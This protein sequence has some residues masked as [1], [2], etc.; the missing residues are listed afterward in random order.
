MINYQK[1]ISLYT[2]ELT[3]KVM[4]FVLKVSKVIAKNFI[5]VNNR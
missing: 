5:Q 4:S 3:G 1:Y 2:Y